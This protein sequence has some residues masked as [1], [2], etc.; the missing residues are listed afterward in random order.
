MCKAAPLGATELRDM[1]CNATSAAQ[2]WRIA[3]LPSGADQGG[4]ALVAAD[5]RLEAALHAGSCA[6]L[7]GKH[8]AFGD[9][10]AADGNAASTSSPATV[11]AIH[12]D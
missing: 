11:R 4:A 7:N 12:I 5:S 9:C 10:L 1:P 8:L 3:A 2:R 6:Y